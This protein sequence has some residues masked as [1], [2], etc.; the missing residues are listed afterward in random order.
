MLI[1][2]VF[3]NQ[4]AIFHW[5][6]AFQNQNYN[7]QCKTLLSETLLNI[8]RNFIPHKIK[9][10]DFKT[11][12][13]VNKSIRL[14]LKNRTKLTKR[15]RMNPRVSNKEALDIESQKCTSLINES[16]DRYIAK[17]SVKLDNPKRVPK[18]YWPTINKF[19]SNKKILI[20]P[21]ILVNGELVSDFTQKANK[22]LNVNKAYGWNQLS[23]RMIKA[24]GNSVSLPLNLIFKSI[25]NEVAFPEDWK[26]SNVVPI[27]KKESKN[28]I[29][30]Y[31]HI[32]LL[33]IFSKVFQRIV[34]NALFNFFLQN[35]L[36]T[37]CQSGF[38]PG[39]SCVFQLLSITHEIYQSFSCHPPPD[40]RGTFL[41]ISKAFDKVWHEGLILK[42]KTYGID[43]KLLKLLENNLTDCQQRVALNGQRSSWQKI[44][45]GVLQGSVLGPLLKEF[46]LKIH[47]TVWITS[48]N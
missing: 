9:K 20:I 38:I 13:W 3:K 25:I 48:N 22:I 42:L 7:E 4:L 21:P 12:E 30:N 23:I 41:D 44:Y 18:R 34:F 8:F 29:K 40:I 16:K 37:P 26:K 6:W 45:A 31:R 36:F 19:L 47:V 10:F 43:G 5:A 15:Y 46:Q 27:H 35:K 24:C 28:L 1:L 2:S 17:M 33:P 39:D 14:S 32:T 11:P